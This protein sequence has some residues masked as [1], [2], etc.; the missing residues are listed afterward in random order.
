MEC[1]PPA[2]APPR[3]MSIADLAWLTDR[4]RL[5]ILSDIEQFR[6]LYM[7]HTR[8]NHRAVKYDV[9]S[10]SDTD[11]APGI[12][13]SELSDC[14]KAVVYSLAG[15]Q[16]E[17]NPH[18]GD[19]RRSFQMGTAVHAMIQNDFLAVA[20]KSMGKFHFEPE[21]LIDRK[22]GGVAEDWEFS[23]TADGLLTLSE[24]GTEYARVGVEL[25]SISDMGYERIRKPE[26]DHIEQSTVYQ[27]GLDAPFWWVAYY[28]KS[29]SNFSTVTP[30]FVREFDASLWRQ[31]EQRFQIAHRHRNDKTLPRRQEGYHCR[32]CTFA[33]TCKPRCLLKPKMAADGR[34]L[35]FPSRL[36]SAG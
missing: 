25:K 18:L 22:L 32:M 2:T 34:V 8:T 35:R 27:A 19:L 23:T 31:L 7:E 1:S 5:R 16:R 15:T 4:D 36:P 21:V 30:A 12:H 10:G 11:R 13:A 28:N 24:H 3:A 14:L 9:R 33:W 6:D 20:E 17:P 29:N 26:P